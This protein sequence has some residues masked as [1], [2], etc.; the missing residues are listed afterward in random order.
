M[1]ALTVLPGRKGPLSLDEV[2]EPDPEQGTILAE[3]LPVGCAP[4]IGRSWRVT[5]A[6]LLS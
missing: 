2:D 3:G 6:G 5:T 4:R 1:G